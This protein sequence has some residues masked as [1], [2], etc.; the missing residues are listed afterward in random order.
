[1]S[2]AMM[3]KLSIYKRHRTELPHPR[4]AFEARGVPFTLHSSGGVGVPPMRI[5]NIYSTFPVK[6]SRYVEYEKMCRLH[7][8]VSLLISVA[9]M[10]QCCILRSTEPHEQAN[11]SSLCELMQS[12]VFIISTSSCCKGI[13]LSSVPCVC[14]CVC[15]CECVCPQ[16]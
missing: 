8:F 10:Y 2:N 4:T 11:N 5:L 3:P 7:V 1:M 12:H 15:V 16:T 14:V 13:I 6:V 9:T